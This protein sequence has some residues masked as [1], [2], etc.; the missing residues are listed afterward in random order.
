MAATTIPIVAL[1]L[2][3][4]CNDPSGGSVQGP[5][6]SAP[7]SGNVAAKPG[8]GQLN[9]ASVNKGEPVPGA[10]GDVRSDKARP[11]AARPKM[12][13][14]KPGLAVTMP[15][16]GAEPRIMFE[17]EFHEFGE[18][19]EGEE[20]ET[21][22]PFKNDGKG[23]LI[24]T[25]QTPHCGCTHAWI[26]VEDKLYT[27]GDPIAPGAKGRVYFV[28]KTAGFQNDK[29]SQLDLHTND[30][31]RGGMTAAAPVQITGGPPFGIVP[32]R[33]HAFIRKQFEFEPSNTLSIGSILNLESKEYTIHVKNTKG[34][35][36]AINKI[37]PDNDPMVQAKFAPVDESRSRWKIDITIPKGQPVGQITKL[38]KIKSDVEIPNGII[39]VLGTLRGAVE[40]DPPGGSVAFG[41]ISKGQ[42]TARQLTV[43]NHHETKVLSIQNLRLLDPADRLSF[44]GERGAK[45]LEAKFADSMRLKVTE[46]A[47]GREA[48]ITIEVLATMPPGM[49][50]ARLAFDTGVEGGPATMTVPLSGYVR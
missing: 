1:L 48:K 19:D 28:L 15:A 30:P 20:L 40:L 5:A 41:A 29:H 47:P 45:A 7:A 13:D 44:T 22:F 37:E 8:D 26:E 9:I 36:F 46:V 14:P 32:L 3:L 21:V 49:F 50:G 10:G 25:N 27:Y 12:A 6:G 23:N 43:K 4:S 2:A 31:A 34:R 33:V 35:A 42:A 24:I 16:P 11:A 18:V 39:Y 38:L 17:S